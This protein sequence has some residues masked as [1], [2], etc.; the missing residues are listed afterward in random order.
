MS[1]AYA[2]LELDVMIAA[3]LERACE[4]A[5]SLQMPAIVVHPL[6]TQQAFHHRSVKKS[7]FK[8]I[9][10][11]DWLKGDQHGLNKF[12]GMSTHALEADGFEILLSLRA[13]YE[14]AQEVE[15]IHSFI[16]NYISPTAE[17]RIV[18]GSLD[19]SLDEA[20]QI[21]GGIVNLDSDYKQKMYVRNDHHTKGQIAKFSPKAHN[22]LID[23]I[24]SMV[25]CKV[26]VS[27]NIDNLRFIS[28]DRADRYAISYLQLQKIIKDVAKDAE[29]IK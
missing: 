23:R 12:V 24:R 16:K 22:D 1:L 7:T 10:T 8:V 14:I 27:G 9:T 25:N 18:L 20:L 5:H 29:K 26:K 4:L 15:D 3:E 13:D 2:K 19:R 28:Q 21:C 17:I 6:L 11:V